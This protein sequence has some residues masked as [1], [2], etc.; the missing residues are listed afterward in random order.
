MINCVKIEKIQ[1]GLI[2][3]KTRLITILIIIILIGV[4]I[5]FTIAQD[6][7]DPKIIIRTDKT[8]YLLDPYYWVYSASKFTLP[9][10]NKLNPHYW[11]ETGHDITVYF[12]VTGVNSGESLIFNVNGLTSLK[13]GYLIEEPAGSGIYHGSF[14][15]SEADVG[16]EAFKPGEV[17]ASNK[18]IV[19]KSII[20]SV[21]K[22][23]PESET[24][25]IAQRN[26]FINRWGCDRCHISKDL[27]MQIYPWCNP[28][29]WLYGPHSWGNILGRNGGRPGF[30]YQ[31]LTDAT[32]THTPTVG[33]YVIN[34]TTNELEYVK[35]PLDRPPY[36][37]KTNQKWAGNIACSPCHQGHDDPVCTVRK[38]TFLP[39]PGNE[40]SREKSLDVKCNYC[41]GID[42][43]YVPADP[44]KPRWEDWNMYSWQ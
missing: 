32:L 19:P 3:M 44:D 30:T 17:D 9:G 23:I 31:N 18:Q 42:G 8:M 27:A 34:S 40:L 4:S 41:H 25:L 1:G 10:P 5:A 13:S 11:Q 36:H 2:K 14:I 21:F 38:T 22:N 24:I 20:L 33:G 7:L 28:T 15:I 37:L 35:N 6:N 43:G 16:G 39:S 12:T 29:G 26:I